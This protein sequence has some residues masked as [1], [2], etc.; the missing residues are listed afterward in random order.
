[1]LNQWLNDTT[2]ALRNEVESWP[3]ALE[4]C[5]QQLLESGI[6]EPGY[7]TA[8]IQ[9]HQKLGDRKSVV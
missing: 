5:A 7:V 6:I 8:I 1:M 4:I 9:Q 2:I 3:Q